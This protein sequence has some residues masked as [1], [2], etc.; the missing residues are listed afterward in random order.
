M[1]EFVQNMPCVGR[2]MDVRWEYALTGPRFFAVGAGLAPPAR[3]SVSVGTARSR[4]PTLCPCRR[5]GGHGQSAERGGM[6]ACLP[7]AWEI[8][9]TF[10]ATTLTPPL[11]RCN[12]KNIAYQHIQGSPSPALRAPSPAGGGNRVVPSARRFRGWRSRL[13]LLSLPRWG[14]EPC[15]SLGAS[16]SGLAVASSA[17]FPPPLGEG[18]VSFPRRVGFE[19]GGR[20]FGSFPSPSGG[21]CRPQAAG[22]GERRI[23]ENITFYVFYPGAGDHAYERPGGRVRSYSQGLSASQRGAPEA[24]S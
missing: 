2:N 1:P 11:Q 10:R 8:A 5:G 22:E 24:A 19:A 9:V 21:G 4:P 17:P 23:Y 18:T 15:R 12:N 7:T 20:V 14:K 13:R 3:Q 6:W 16:V